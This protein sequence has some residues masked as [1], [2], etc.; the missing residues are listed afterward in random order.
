[1]WLISLIIITLTAA[2]V[3]FGTRSAGKL[4]SARKTET[5][6]DILR[7]SEREL[8][9]RAQLYGI[10]EAMSY[11]QTLDPLIQEQFYI[12]NNNNDEIMSTFKAKKPF[13]IVQNRKTISNHNN[14]FYDRWGNYFRLEIEDVLNM[15]IWFSLS[16][17]GYALRTF[18][19]LFISAI[20]AYFLAY[21]MCNSILAIAATVREV[22]NGNMF[23]KISG[24]FMENKDEVG[25][26]AHSINHMIES[27]RDMRSNEQ[28][29]LSDV[30]HDLRSPLA[31]Q[32]LALNFISKKE[33]QFNP[34][35]LNEFIE[36]AEIE[37]ERLND[38]IS[39]V[40]IYLR[41]ENSNTSISLSPISL[42]QILSEVIE[43]AAFEAHPQNKVI[44][45]NLQEDIIILGIYPKLIRAFEN[46]VRNAV[47]HTPMNTTITINIDNSDSHIVRIDIIDQG[48]GVP[49]NKVHLLTRPFFRSD[50]SRGTVNGGYGLGLPICQAIINEHLGSLAIANIDPHGLKVSISLNKKK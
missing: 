10:N 32:K 30:A 33:V 18:I 20:A 3:L 21:Q 45:C 2:L 38:L 26:L 35:K 19:S 47:F 36:R 50:S 24:T 13:W 8:I 22:K 7:Q 12:Y 23:A 9:L 15:P 41:A 5:H 49:E 17:S 11:V 37:N 34:L 31:R 14:E 28:Q 29:L 48:D 6:M 44:H 4:A 40:L 27:I 25:Q 46:V 16:Y 43:D 39:E 1:M 42:N